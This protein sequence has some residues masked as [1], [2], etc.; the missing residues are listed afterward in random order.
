MEN[1]EEKLVIITKRAYENNQIGFLFRDFPRDG[2]EQDSGWTVTSGYETEEEQADSTQFLL[3]CVN[4]VLEIDNRLEKIID[5]APRCAFGLN[6]Q[7]EFEK[8]SDF[9]WEVYDSE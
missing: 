7:G 9:D 3:V 4:C 2:T 5:T 1:R 6:E 8:V